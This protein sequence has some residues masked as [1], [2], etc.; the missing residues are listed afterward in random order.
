MTLRTIFTLALLSVVSILYS[1]SAR[2]FTTD[3]DL[4]SSLINF[5]YEDSYGNIWVS[6]EDGLNKYNGSK[7][8]T[9]RHD[10]N[11]TTSL[12]HS[13]VR[14]MLEDKEGNLYVCTAKG[15]QVYNPVTDSFSSLAR[16][17][18]GFE[19]SV[20]V[21]ALACLSDG[22]I[23]AV[24]A[25]LAELKIENGEFKASPFQLP[26]PIN[27]VNAIFEDSKHNLWLSRGEDGVYCYSMITGEH[28]H[29]LA[30]FKNSVVTKFDEDVDG[31]VI[32]AVRGLGVMKFDVAKNDFV[33][34]EEVSIYNK[35]VQ[36]LK[37]IEDY[38]ILI[39]YDGYGLKSLDTKT[40][41]M[42]EWNV[43]NSYIDLRSSKIHAILKDSY[44]NI[45]L[46]VYQKGLIMIPNQIQPFQYIGYK[47]ATSNIIGS[48]AIATICQSKSGDYF[49]GTDN[50]GVYKLSK[51]RKTSRHYEPS[52]SSQMPSIVLSLYEDARGN[53]WYGTYSQGC[54]ILDTKTGMCKPIVLK[55]SDG[56]EATRVYNFCEDY[57]NRVWIAT[58]GYGLY[59]YDYNTQKAT[60]LKIINGKVNDW[61]NCLYFSKR[62]Q[63]LFA[64]TY[65]G[66]YVID[67]ED[68]VENSYVQSFLPIIFV[69]SIHEDSLGNLWYGTS[70]GLF[71]HSPDDTF[72]QFT[73]NEGIAGSTV[74]AVEEDG[75]DNLWFSTN[76]GLTQMNMRTYDVV[77][78]YYGDGLQGN[79]FCKN[80]SLVDKDGYMWF[81]GMWGVS[82]FNPSMVSFQRTLWKIQMSDFYVLENRVTGGESFSGVVV[83]DTIPSLSKLF[84]LSYS[85]NSFSFDLAPKNPAMSDALVYSYSINGSPWVSR[86]SGVSHI[87]F[88]NMP[89]GEYN[90]SVR[91]DN[92][93]TS[94]DTIDFCVLVDEKPWLSWWA[95]TFY[96][97][98]FLS[99]IYATWR[100][101]RVRT[102]AQQKI[103]EHERE[104]EEK[105]AKLQF[106]INIAHE[107]RTP[108]TLVIS[109]LQQLMKN[110]DDP[111]KRHTSYT[112][113]N[114]NA[115]RILRLVGQLL[116]IR[117]IDKGQM[118]LSLVEANLTKLVSDVCISFDQYAKERNISFSFMP[119]KDGDVLARLDP[120]NFDKIIYNILSNAFK[121]TPEGGNISVKLER[122]NS[123]IDILVCDTGNGINDEELE[124]IFDRFYQAR[125]NKDMS[126]LGTGI[127]LHLSRM[128]VEMHNGTIKARRNIHGVGMTFTVT[129]PIIGQAMPECDNTDNPMNASVAEYHVEASNS[130][131]DTSDHHRSNIHVLI[132]E[133]DDSI[134]NYL[135]SELSS[136]FNVV[137]CKNGREA[138]EQMFKQKP[139]IVLSD[140]MMPEL[141]GLSLCRRIK[142][143]VG[144]IDIPVIILTAKSHD[145]DTI[146]G[147]D[148]GADL[149]LTKPFNIDVLRK[150]IEKTV[151][152]RKSLKTKYSNQQEKVADKV[153]HI[154]AKSPDERLLER[155]M[156]AL[157]KHIGDASLTVDM[158]AN[159]IGISRVHLNRKLKE[160]TNQTT[161]TF[162]RTIR[163]QVASDMLLKKRHSI[164]EVAE[165]TGFSD[166]NNFS[167]AFKQHFGVS[168]SVYSK[169]EGTP[170]E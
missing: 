154:D 63:K 50:D 22:R 87:T 70:E 73:Q 136:R 163:L 91:A 37:R 10:E 38:S 6:T 59:M 36:T 56:I 138:W 110:D 134:R 43:D 61:V 51:D 49:I 31:N 95:K 18:N 123:D 24:S 89:S 162:I 11:D 16:F 145:E 88:S 149:Y 128:L 170:A 165:M 146:E 85:D 84:H 117:K 122:R 46:G 101:Y 40:M 29:Y 118:S 167:T 74:Y 147:L 168:P 48:A 124:H 34:L 92:R 152:I 44:N 62:Y 32:A 27:N 68:S 137:S 114:N 25:F 99:L 160:L 109:P 3:G 1:Q 4:S 35:S 86:P 106:F 153:V 115:Q 103:R 15:I 144:F 139:D 127:G 80:S 52:S 151:E 13:Y 41:T 23:V 111:Q 57:Q 116:D 65:S 113:M 96:W 71:K 119:G 102:D 53:M 83:T 14:E 143:H 67:V 55:D 64:G 69:Y 54:G 100:Q 8:V 112:L 161:T 98:V 107:I 90:F 75:H 141:D 150:T 47:S 82:Y 9:Y 155:V 78:H 72:R 17:S 131:S 132:A 5:I 159:E 142:Q 166:S 125:S 169:N 105:E 164:A 104:E 157:N 39:G 7:F 158:L 148:V 130:T 121:F 156:K 135:Q 30:S 94:S 19:M 33:A 2:F 133:D 28:T 126:N 77:N 45:W 79:E 20:N 26:F 21:N 120:E 76:M 97:L 12:R 60:E 81:G 140:V 58:M 108:M 93:T 66:I 129:M 42:K